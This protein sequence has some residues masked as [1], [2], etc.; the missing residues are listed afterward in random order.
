MSYITE[1]SATGRLFISRLD[2]LRSLIVAYTGR[3][4]R[5]GDQESTRR[6][7]TPTPHWWLN[8]AKG[9]VH[10]DITVSVQKKRMAITIDK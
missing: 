10:M 9:G 6:I 3:R 1:L 8:D 7:S 2:S 4:R 5:V